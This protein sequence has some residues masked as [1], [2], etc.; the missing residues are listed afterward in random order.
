MCGA[1]ARCRPGTITITVA[2]RRGIGRLLT[3]IEDQ[4]MRQ[5][6][7]VRRRSS[8]ATRR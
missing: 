6:R 2:R 5:R 8:F 4:Q 1:A 7:Q 3:G